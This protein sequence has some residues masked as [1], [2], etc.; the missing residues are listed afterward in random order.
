[1]QHRINNFAKK[2]LEDTA[3]LSEDIIS[4]CLHHSLEDVIHAFTRKNLLPD[5]IRQIS[6]VSVWYINSA[7]W[8]H[9]NECTDCSCDP[10]L[11]TAEE[12]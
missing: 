5:K 2:Y 7:G 12:D 9:A 3:Q 6:Q 10:S 11:I 4:A 8:L 1:M